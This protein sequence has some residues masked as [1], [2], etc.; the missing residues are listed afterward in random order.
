[1]NVVYEYPQHGRARRFF[2]KLMRLI[3]ALLMMVGLIAAVPTVLVLVAF[4]W[5]LISGGSI[6]IKD[7]ELLKLVGIA[8]VMILSLFLGRWLLRGR[9]QLVL[10]LR[11]FG[12]VGA[13][14]ALTFALV[15]AIGHSWRV[16]T[17]DDHRVAPVGTGRRIRWVSVIVTLLAL[18]II[19]VGF[20]WIFNGGLDKLFTPNNAKTLPEALGQIFAGFIVAILVIVLFALQITF[21]ALI[22][23]FS[24]G[25]YLSV[26]RAEKSKRV[27][28]PSLERIDPMA[29]SVSRRSRRVLSP[30]L[31]V[32]QVAGPVW[33][34][35]VRRLALVCAAVVIDVSEPSMNLLWEISM[36]KSDRRFQSIF[37]AEHEHLIRMTNPGAQ[38]AELSRRLLDVLEGEDVIAYSSDRQGRKRFARALRNRLYAIP[39]VRRAA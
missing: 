16:V 7:D 30:K 24:F 38:N 32:V 19:A 9:R 15:T 10:L 35:T 29:R 23:L 21:F 18:G 2:A 31:I 13:T 28:V 20:L 5:Q 27:Q 14:E 12:F 36:L 33:Q 11:R 37:V 25:S 26:R 1:M 17:L 22:G 8:A 4:V 3:G 39:S 6:R 34:E